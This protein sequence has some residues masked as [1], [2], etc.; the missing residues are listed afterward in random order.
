MTRKRAK[1]VPT[2]EYQFPEEFIYDNEKIMNKFFKFHNISNYNGICYYKNC[3]L[4]ST[5]IKMESG[6]NRKNIDEWT[7]I[8]LNNYLKHI[9][10]EIEQIDISYKSLHK[11]LKDINYV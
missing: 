8:D 4:V 7:V 2:G 11:T 6:L 3:P 1:T 10:E 5:T 9:A